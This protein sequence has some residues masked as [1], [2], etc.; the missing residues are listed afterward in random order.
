MD[1]NIGLYPPN[2]TR[3]HPYLRA[4]Y[5]NS[6]LGFGR[7]PFFLSFNLFIL[8]SFVIKTYLIHCL[9]KLKPNFLTHSLRIH[10]FRLFGPKS[11][12]ILGQEF[13]LGP[14]KSRITKI[15]YIIII[16]KKFLDPRGAWV[17]PCQKVSTC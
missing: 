3:A 2:P 8:H 13:K 6:L 4:I 5:K 14:Y 1:R 17:R 16:N 9:V 15:K 10:C 7:G 11:I 12:H